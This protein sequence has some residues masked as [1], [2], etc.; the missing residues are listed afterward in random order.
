MKPGDQFS[1]ACAQHCFKVKLMVTMETLS[2]LTVSKWSNETTSMAR[3]VTFQTV[4]HHESCFSDNILASGCADFLAKLQSQWGSAAVGLFQIL[5]VRFVKTVST[6]RTSTASEERPPIQVASSTLAL[7]KPCK[8]N[9]QCRCS[10]S[11]T[12]NAMLINLST[13][14]EIR[15]GYGSVHNSK[16]ANEEGDAESDHLQQ[17]S[18]LDHRVPPPSRPFLCYKSDGGE[19]SLS[20]QS[21]CQVQCG[22][23]QERASA[24]DK[25]LASDEGLFSL[26]R[27]SRKYKPRGSQT[28]TNSS[29]EVVRC[30]VQMTMST[31]T[32][33]SQSAVASSAY[34]TA[35]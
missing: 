23:D 18:A 3:V 34:L 27:C 28:V 6:H 30:C 12:V 14:E 10:R 19:Q 8:L 33:S 2:A 22:G 7:T 29:E 13:L 16:G 21:S 20:R 17:I 4:P 1:H 26:G 15:S 9:Y 31:F 24:I 11:T 35:P 5:Q 32:K 25:L